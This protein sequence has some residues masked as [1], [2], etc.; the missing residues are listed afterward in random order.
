MRE[1]P[2]LLDGRL[3]AREIEADLTRRVARILEKTGEVPT[4]ATILVG[5]DPASV[6]YYARKGTLAPGSA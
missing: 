6:T 3:L 4:L 1:P 5:E 2:I